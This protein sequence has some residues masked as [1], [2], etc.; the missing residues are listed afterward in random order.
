MAEGDLNSINFV[1][2]YLHFLREKERFESSN[3]LPEQLDLDEMHDTAS[4]LEDPHSSENT[5]GNLLTIS[6]SLTNTNSQ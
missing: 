1:Q 2:R 4:A 6:C 3:K 5:V